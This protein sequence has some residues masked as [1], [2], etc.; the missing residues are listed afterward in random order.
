MLTTEKQRLMARTEPKYTFNVGDRASFVPYM[1]RAR[2]FDKE[3]ELSI[4]A[5][6]DAKSGS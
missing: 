4:L 1:E 6:L 5:E 3:S 2:Y